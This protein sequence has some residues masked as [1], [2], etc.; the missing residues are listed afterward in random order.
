MRAFPGDC[1]C[2]RFVAR[3]D[4]VIQTRLPAGITLIKVAV[5]FRRSHGIEKTHAFKLMP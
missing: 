3:V 4:S 2:H 5:F 1:L